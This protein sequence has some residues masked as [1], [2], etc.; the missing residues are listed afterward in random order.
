MCAPV[1]PV[2][3][4]SQFTDTTLGRSSCVFLCAYWLMYKPDGRVIGRKGKLPWQKPFGP[5]LPLELQHFFNTTANGVLIVGRRTFEETG[6]CYAHAAH[7]VVVSEDANGQIRAAGATVVPSVAHAVKVAQATDVALNNKEPNIWVCG[8]ARIYSECMERK[9]AQEL[10]LTLI[11]KEFEGAG[12]CV[13]L[14]GTLPWC[15]ITT[16]R[17]TFCLIR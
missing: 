6:A 1:G 3:A 5:G 12:C 2:T 11:D 4:P 17:C 14:C 10:V 9:L 13:V 8:G 15:P 7:T 16:A